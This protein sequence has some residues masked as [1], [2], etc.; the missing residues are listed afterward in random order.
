MASRTPSPG[1]RFLENTQHRARRIVAGVRPEELR[2]VAILF[3]V[4]TWVAFAINTVTPGLVDR[5]G[6]LKGAD[7][8]QFYVLGHLAS[9]RAEDVLY[10]EVAYALETNRLVPETVETFPPVYPPQVSVFFAPLSK[11]SY[12]WA[13]L[14]WSLIST[15]L[16]GVS[17]FLVWRRC[18][19]LAL[20]GGVIGWLAVGSPA[21]FSLVGHGQTTSVV[22]ALL[23]GMFLALQ[24]DRPVLAGVLL[25]L[26]AYKPQ[27]GIAAG[28][29]LLVSREWRIVMGAALGVAASVAVGWLYWGTPTM[30]GYL[31][32][33]SNPG[34]L[35]MIVEQKLYHSHSLRTLWALLIPW[36]PLA[37]ALFGLTAVW[38]LHHT[39]RAW[40]SPAPLERRFA[41]VLIA[42]VLVSPHVFVYDLVIL[43]P[44]LIILANWSLSHPEHPMSPSMK[45]LL[46]AAWLAP[47]VGFLADVTQLQLSVLVFVALFYMATT[48]ETETA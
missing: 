7:F 30:L 3:A 22:V 24:A 10:D 17:C 40:Q 19:A 32:V 47:A 31:G 15:A 21:F 26:L 46:V 35:T 45:I 44:A 33:L 18:G 42:T 13:V 9:D 1:R 14:V 23:V 41:V 37:M 2:R 25:G 27:V 12:G 20:F 8:L 5:A 48:V 34:Q 39:V 43:A 29:T 28:L 36:R 4:V 38:V 6:Q 16:Y 11:L